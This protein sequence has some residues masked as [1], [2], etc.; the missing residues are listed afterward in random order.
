MRLAQPLL[1]VVTIV[2]NN[3]EGL[4][5]TLCN[6][7]GQSYTNIEYIVVDGGSTDETKLVIEQY[8]TSID[9]LISERDKGIYDAMNKG[10]RVA[11][12][13]YVCFMNAGDC[14]YTY[15]TVTEVF[16]N[17]SVENSADVYY[18]ETVM[19]NEND[20][21]LGYRT[22]K[23]LP[24]NLSWKDMIWGM[25]VC[26]QSL[27]VRRKIAPLY[28]LAHHYSGDIDWTIRV[29]KNAKKIHNTQTII[30]R[31]L[32]GGFSAQ[33]R[34]QSLY[35]RFAILRKHFGLIPTIVVQ[36]LI[37]IKYLFYKIFPAKNQI[38]Y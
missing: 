23:K 30:S 22:H 16:A 37:V 15:E 4:A 2:F 12:G 27:I 10:L 29:L 36:G 26:H 11:S 6:V 9:R 35:D 31:F 1:S 34:K 38:K 17:F 14:F 25:V 32:I 24:Q 33:K 8:K 20:T 18:G 19:V 7:R 3:P 13:E 5:K 28:D 21:V